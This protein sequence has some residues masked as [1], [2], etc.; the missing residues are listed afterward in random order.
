MQMID[1]ATLKAAK[2]TDRR[3][4]AI[5]AYEN[6]SADPGAANW[7]TIAD[8][9]RLAMPASKAKPATTETGSRFAPWADYPIPKSATGHKLGK[10]PVV[11]VTFADGEI[12]R[13]PAVS[14]PGK[15]LN[16]GRA[17][18]VAIAFYQ[19]RIAGRMGANSDSAHVVS[20]PAM[21]N[22]VCETT[23]AE[24]DPADCSSRSVEW[25]AGSFDLAAART[26]AKCKSEDAREKYIRTEFRI[27]VLASRRAA[28]ATEYSD[29]DRA[30]LAYWAEQRPAIR[31]AICNAAGEMWVTTERAARLGWAVMA[32]WP[33]LAEPELVLR[34][35]ADAPPPV[36]PVE[37]V[38]SPPA[39]SNFRIAP[40]FLHSSRLSVVP[41]RPAVA[42]SRGAAS[43]LRVA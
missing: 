31:D 14:M 7:R 28:G 27:A 13:A 3:A 25:R 36:A 16:I 4:L 30:E 41:F 43:I 12:V 37:P 1:I 42:P 2:A 22:V 6:A 39:T 29:N 26:D 8:M 17:L 33:D 32:F 21:V 24:F 9:L 23:G 34:A 15:P 40:R 20:A 5:L 18:R 19:C 35:A 10:S 38:A 11:V